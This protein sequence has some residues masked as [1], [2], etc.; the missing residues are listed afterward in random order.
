MLGNKRDL[1]CMFEMWDIPSPYKSGAPKPPF[2]RRV[3]NLTSTL[4]AYSYLGT[5][6]WYRQLGKCIGK[7]KGSPTSAQNNMNFGPQTA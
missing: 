4:T 3:R 2:F 6:T 5:K 1:K 7:Q